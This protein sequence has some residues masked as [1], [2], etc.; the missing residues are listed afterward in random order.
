ML[1]V[2]PGDLFYGDMDQKSDEDDDDSDDEPYKNQDES[3][4]MDEINKGE[5]NCDETK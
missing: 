1:C 2:V 3:D 4:K 5:S